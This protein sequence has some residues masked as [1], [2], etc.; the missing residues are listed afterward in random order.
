MHCSPTQVVNYTKGNPKHKKWAS[1][2]ADGIFGFFA[3]VF[4]LTR[5]G[6]YPYY[7]VY[8]C[9]LR[10]Y[11][12]IFRNQIFEKREYHLPEAW[13]IFNGLLSVLQLLHLF[14]AA[15]ILKMV[16]K[17]SPITVLSSN[18][19]SGSVLRVGVGRARDHN[20]T[21]TDAFR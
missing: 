9:L 11:P 15:L 5:L 1:P 10:S 12:V 14:W 17:A 6:L 16:Y 21:L 7:C 13:Y 8:N 18:V 4:F 20:L 3:I 19:I 2:A